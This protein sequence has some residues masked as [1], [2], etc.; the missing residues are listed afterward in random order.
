MNRVIG[1]TDQKGIPPFDWIAEKISDSMDLSTC[2]DSAQ[3]FLFTGLISKAEISAPIVA[4]MHM[5][6]IYSYDCVVSKIYRPK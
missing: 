3:I 6:I 2:P 4:I 1:L 5:T